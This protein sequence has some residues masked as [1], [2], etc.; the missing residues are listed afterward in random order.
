MM[1][2]QIQLIHCMEKQLSF[3]KKSIRNQVTQNGLL[4]S[5]LQT[6]PIGNNNYQQHPPLGLVVSSSSSS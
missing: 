1:R 6:H 3:I 2:L 5:I 4:Y